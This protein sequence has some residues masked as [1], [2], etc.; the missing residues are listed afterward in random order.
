MFAEYILYAN[1]K[2][3]LTTMGW[4]CFSPAYMAGPS[5]TH[6]EKKKRKEKKLVRQST[7]P[8]KSGRTCFSLALMVGPGPAQTQKKRKR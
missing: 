1:I 8:P 4:T 5:L 3:P 2:M 7:S 6:N